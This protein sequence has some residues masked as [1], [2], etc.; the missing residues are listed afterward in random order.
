[1]TI[2][3]PFKDIATIEEEGL[4]KICNFLTPYEE[5]YSYL[6]EL[7]KTQDGPLNEIETAFVDAYTELMYIADF[8]LNRLTNQDDEITFVL[9]KK[10]RPMFFSATK[11]FDNFVILSY[12]YFKGLLCN[13]KAQ[14][15]CRKTPSNDYTKFLKKANSLVKQFPLR[16]STCF[17]ETILSPTD[18][19]IP[20]ASY[21]VKQQSTPQLKQELLDCCLTCGEKNLKT[22]NKFMPKF[23]ELASSLQEAG[24]SKKDLKKFV[25]AVSYLKKCESRLSQAIS[26]LEE[27]GAKPEKGEE[28]SE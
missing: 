27:I 25:G 10:F 21:F 24:F 18:L 15:L 2:K 5:A 3:N 11:A 7:R 19:L 22:I 26:Y 8:S 20:T 14:K 4:E 16:F 6:D 28:E 13:K 12:H 17:P 1:M 23:A 9:S